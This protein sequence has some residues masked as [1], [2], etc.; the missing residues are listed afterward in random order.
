MTLS[1]KP[2][3]YLDSNATHPLLPAVRTA[4]ARALVEDDPR[5]GN[6]A[7]IHQRGQVAKMEMAELRESLCQYLGRPDGDEF[8]FLSGATEAINMAMRGFVRE[9]SEVGRKAALL[10][11]SVEHSAVL[12]T[13]KDLGH[14]AILAVNSQGQLDF[15]DISHKSRSV[16]GRFDPRCFDLLTTLQ[17]RNRCRF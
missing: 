3:I 5:L 12:D 10:V 6:P 11:T 7:S 2:M 16:V 15:S 17:Q 13:A 14:S 8:I 4:L 1:E 9:R